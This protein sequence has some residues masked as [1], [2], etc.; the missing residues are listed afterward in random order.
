MTDSSVYRFDAMSSVVGGEVL[1]ISFEPT[2]TIGRYIS[3]QSLMKLSLLA[4][5]KSMS[6]FDSVNRFV[7]YDMKSSGSFAL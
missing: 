2:D 3:R 4:S 7:P 5:S 1:G 6:I